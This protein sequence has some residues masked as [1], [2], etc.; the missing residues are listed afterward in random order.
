MKPDTKPKARK[1]ASRARKPAD[2]IPPHK[3]IYLHEYESK[4]PFEHPGTG[5]VAAESSST[6]PVTLSNSSIW[7]NVAPILGVGALL[8]LSVG[9]LLAFVGLSYFS[10][11]K[12]VNVTINSTSGWQAT[13]IVLNKNAMLYVDYI[14]GG[15][16]VDANI[17]GMVGSEGYP[18]SVD[19]QIWDP[20]QCKIVQSAPYGALVGKIGN[21]PVFEVGRSKL[22]WFPSNGELFL[23]INDKYKCSWDN[24]GQV[25][26]RVTTK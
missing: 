6:I 1:R 8:A 18:V 25:T 17:Y 12:A 3:P 21:G 2:W 26:V 10:T 23:S 19:R 16:T 15:W 5:S 24:Q 4:N 14:S 20:S 22:I 13:G 7:G 11:A 9:A